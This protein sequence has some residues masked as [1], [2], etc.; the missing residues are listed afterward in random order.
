MKSFAAYISKYFLSYARFI[1][2]LLFLNVLAFFYTFYN[3]VSNA[4]DET[5]PSALLPQV[6]AASSS[7]GIPPEMA[8]Y[9]SSHDIWAMYL[10]SQGTLLWSVNLPGE[11]PAT[12]TIQEV[13][14]FSK[15]YLADYPVFVWSMDDGLL[16]LGYPQDSY[17]KFT[18][19]YYPVELIRIMPGFFAGMLILDLFL[20]F[21]AYFF[22]KRSLLKNTAPLTTSIQTLANGKPV[23]LSMKGELAEIADSIN[24][25]SLLLSRQNTAR[26]NWISGVSHDIRTPLSMIM[27]Y[28]ER[29]STDRT[30]NP[31]IQE[32]ASIIQKQSIR[33][34][35]LIQDLNLVSQL[36]YDMQPLHKQPV[37]MAKLL[38]SYAADMLNAGLPDKYSFTLDIAPDTDC[39]IFECDERL[40]NRAIHNLVQNCI[41]HNPQGCD[42]T[43]SLA[44]SSHELLVIVEDN[45]IGLSAEKQSELE[46]KPHYM[47]STD[48]RLDLRHGLGLLIV[49]QITT[50]HHG[51]M[52][53]ESEPSKGFKTSLRFPIG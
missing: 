3:I 48:E 13:A 45:G 26:A 12:Y 53:I 9:L 41:Q 27:G 2:V 31:A 52:L 6:A 17:F 25:A 18:R 11:L 14:V 35:E 30:V 20:L 50:A 46:E 22:S 37:R 43:L 34:K 29:I 39:V 47:C 16:V 23:S 42:I 10:N 8:N 36:E 24:K 32:Q 4:Y 21:F 1:I 38:R 19:N 51:T 7:E 40:L 44:Y 5:T 33:I 49:R 15:G 28:A